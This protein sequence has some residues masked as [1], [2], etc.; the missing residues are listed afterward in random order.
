MIFEEALKLL[1]EGKRVIS[2]KDKESF[3]NQWLSINE[4]GLITYMNQPWNPSPEWLLYYI[5]DEWIN[6]EEDCDYH[7]HNQLTGKCNK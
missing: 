7:D 1:K 6:V 5:N 3:E 4:D 2:K